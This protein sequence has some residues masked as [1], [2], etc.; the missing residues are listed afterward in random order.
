MKTNLDVRTVALNRAIQYLD[1][2]GAQYKII[3][4]DGSEY[5]KLEAAVPKATRAPSRY[6]RGFVRE[7]CRSVMSVMQKGDVVEVPLGD[8]DLDSIQNGACS[9]AS[10]LW[11]NG[12]V[13][14]HKKELA[15]C[16]EV[17]RTK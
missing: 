5:G 1:S 10:D 15:N 14:T 16:V 4:Q 9:L 3:L 17:L 8:F 7:H 11:G 12:S 13:I 2:L 6:P